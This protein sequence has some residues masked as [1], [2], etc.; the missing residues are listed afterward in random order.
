M[1]KIYSTHFRDGMAPKYMSKKQGRWSKTG[2]YENCLSNIY[3]KYLKKIVKYLNK[4]IFKE[5]L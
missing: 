1:Y 2:S 3:R 4:E 5:D